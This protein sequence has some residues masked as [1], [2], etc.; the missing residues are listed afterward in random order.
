MN[1]AIDL[2]NDKRYTDAALQIDGALR[3]WPGEPVAWRQK[4]LI[5][6]QANRG[7][8]ALQDFLNPASSVALNDPTNL[9]TQAILY[10]GLKQPDRAKQLVARLPAT[11]KPAPDD[12]RNFKAVCG[13]DLAR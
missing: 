4:A 12:K 7:E 9:I 5:F 1:F 2:M 8:E 6:L 10:C 3:D 13:Q 11:F